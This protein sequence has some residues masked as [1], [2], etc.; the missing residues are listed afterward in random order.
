MMSL[1]LL[2]LV[3]VIAHKNNIA[4]GFHIFSIVLD[5][6]VVLLS[7]IERCSSHIKT[8]VTKSISETR[9]YIQIMY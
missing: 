5:E 1:H 9:K 7:I 3:D 8:I 4:N 6:T 2:R